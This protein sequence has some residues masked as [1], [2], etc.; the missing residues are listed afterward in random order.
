MAKA[1]KRRRRTKRRVHPLRQGSL[2]G[3]CGVYSVVNAVRLLCPEVDLE[4]AEH[5][6]DQLTQKLLRTVGNHTTAV[7]W[8]IGRLMLRSLIDEAVTYMLDEFDIQ[9]KARRLPKEIRQGCSR[10][11]LW[12]AL[13]EMVS[14]TCVAILGLAGQHSHW[15]VASH[16]SAVSIRLFDSGRLQA[17]RRGRCTVRKTNKRHQIAPTHVMLIER[18]A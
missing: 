2:D 13:E 5:L 3:L 8:G 6:F 4:T 14:P 17:L 18:S 11:Q 15:T 9:L 7:T 16:V 1:T 10:D 12:Q